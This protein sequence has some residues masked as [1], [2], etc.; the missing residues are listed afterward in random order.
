ML[1]TNFHMRILA[2]VIVAMAGLCIPGQ[3]LAGPLLKMAFIEVDSP[4]AVKKLAR[5]GIDIAAV[6]KIEDPQYPAAPIRYRVEAV[7]SKKDE[8]KLRRQGIKWRQVAEKKALSGQARAQAAAA[9]VY[10]SFDEPETGIRDR[11]TRIATDYPSLTKLETIGHSLQERPLLALRIGAKSSNWWSAPRRKSEVLFL[12]THHAREWMA[13]FMAMRLIDY[14]TGNYGKDPRVT[15]LLDSTWVWVVPVA[16]PDGYQYTFDVERLWRKNL[17]DN[18]GDGRITIADGV[19]L[20]RNFNSH[21]GLDEEGSSAVISD[22]AYRGSLPESEPETRAV[23]KFINAHDFKFLLS[24]HTYSDL[25]LYPWGWQVKTPSLDDPIFVAQAGTDDQPSIWD[26][27]IGQGYNPGVGADLYTTNGDFTD[28][29]YAEAGIPSYAVELTLG[30]DVEGNYYGFEF[31]DDPDL[32]ETVFQDNLEFALSLAES[33]ADPAHP[34]SPAGIDVQYA[35]H[36]PLTTSYGSDQMID[37]LLSNRNHVHSWLLYR[38]NDNRFRWQRF[39]PMPG[40]TYNDQPGLY[41]S[42]YQARVKGQRTGDTVTYR[43]VTGGRSLGP[44]SYTVAQAGES[45]VLVLSTEDYTGDYPAYNDTGGPNYLDYY[46]SALDSIGVSYDVWDVTARNMAP[47]YREALS[48]YAAVIWYTGDNYAA[49]VPD[50][51]VTEQIVLGL[52]DLMNYS[53]GKLMASGQD[54]VAPAVSYDL[55]SDDFFQYHLGAYLT[56]DRSGMDPESGLPFAVRGQPGDPVFDGLSFDLSGGD[57]AGNQVNPDTFLATSHFLP[58]FSNTVAARYVRPGGPFDPHGGDYYIYSQMAD[59]AYKR[60]GGTFTLPDGAP[61]LSFWISHDI[62][63][64]WD[65]AFVEIR[66]EGSDDWTTLPDLNGLTTT[67]TGQSCQSGWVADIH[68]HLAHYI[69]DDCNP[70]GTSG[71]WN[72]FTGSSNGWQQVVFDLSAYAGRTVEIHIAYASDWDNQNLGVFIDDI[73]ISGYPAEGFE[74]DLGRFSITSA[75]NTPFNNWTR[76]PTGGFTEGPVIRTLDSVFMGFGFEAIAGAENR[77]AVM[78]RV[79]DYLLPAD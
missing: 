34:K 2:G 77:T 70:T 64:D 16:N 11:L 49:T 43:I 33:A 58:H 40:A 38:I 45:K 14:L 7:V 69:D 13:A 27:L 26:S 75:D 79:M 3:A 4:V 68:P 52:R 9:T 55:L 37:V 1:K 61:Q 15:D 6:R 36:T 12:A 76:L 72:A 28:W 47:P 23:V 73:E 39:T 44:Y 50:M 67:T 56:V 22:A 10:H 59:Q 5:M 54:L 42:R 51:G 62:E 78:Q 24:Y 32:V 63:P 31:P 21:W 74:T 17:R 20:N 41:Y 19:D 18:D 71:Q 30:E 25:I 65:F 53:G 29:T 35:Y 66:T 46:T 57:S 48:N 8:K 60:L